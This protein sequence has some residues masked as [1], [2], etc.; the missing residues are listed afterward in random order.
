[1]T[2]WR[3]IVNIFN[4]AAWTQLEYLD[5]TN[6]QITRFPILPGSLKHLILAD[7]PLLAIHDVPELL[8]LTSMPLLETFNVHATAIDSQA[9]RHLTSDA[10]IHQH[11]KK[12]NLG[13]R[14]NATP[15][16]PVEQEFPKSESVE[17]LSLALLHLKDDRAMDI[18]ELY[19]NL[20]RLDMSGTKIT[21]VAVKDFVKRGI[22]KMKLDECDSISPDA[23]EWARGKG[24]EISYNFPSRTGPPRFADSA[25]A[26]GV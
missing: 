14:M 18:V 20:R 1:M 26:R 8:T 12:F 11:L 13:G 5:L 17:E 19:P 24:I 9:V 21:G 25:L 10:I 2:E 3:I 4:L 6:T 7:N 22:I 23:V 15:D 16:I